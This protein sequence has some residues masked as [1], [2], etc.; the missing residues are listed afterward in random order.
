MRALQKITR[1]FRNEAIGTD[2]IFDFDIEI[3]VSLSGD[4][5]DYSGC[6]FKEAT[7][8]ISLNK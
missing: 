7:K 4:I 1:F 3:Y 2:Y 5:E 8:L 6:S